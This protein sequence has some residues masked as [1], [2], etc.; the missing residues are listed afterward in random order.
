[1]FMGVAPLC[2]HV[3]TPTDPSPRAPR[4]PADTLS[5]GETALLM[6]A[7]SLLPLAALTAAAVP[8]LTL[9]GAV[10]ATTLAA[11]PR[12][13]RRLRTRRERRRLCVPHTEVCTQV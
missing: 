7:L 2:L 11:T 9:G 8:L 3:M 6:A 13:V 10:G 12:V 1:M 5:L 4:G